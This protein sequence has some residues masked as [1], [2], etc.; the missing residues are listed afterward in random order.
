[1]GKHL[2]HA[3]PI[4]N[5]LKQGDAVLPLIFSFVLEYDTKVPENQKGLELN[6][7]HQLLVYPGDVNL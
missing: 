5:C 2:C 3:F 6:G 4:Q 7:K 1:M